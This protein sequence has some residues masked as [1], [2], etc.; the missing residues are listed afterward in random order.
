MVHLDFKGA[1]PSLAYLKEIF[2]LIKKAG[3]N[4]L[5]IEYEDMFPYWGKI[6]NASALNAF[7]V[8][9]IQELLSAAKAHQ[10]EVIPLVQTFGHLE[11]VL[12][13]EEFVPLREV[14]NNPLSL[15]PSKQESFELVKTMIDQVMTLH[16]GKKFFAFFQEKFF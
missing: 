3:G 12:K 4:S 5:L 6:V 7:T 10:L 8:N 1:P 2:P 15:C 11:H 13:L 16:Q 9:Q 14:Q